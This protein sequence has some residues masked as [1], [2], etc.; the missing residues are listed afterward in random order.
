MPLPAGQFLLHEA[1]SIA[2]VGLAS[3]K[4]FARLGLVPV[5]AGGGVQGC[6]RRF[7]AVG[8]LVLCVVCEL[9]RRGLSRAAIGLAVAGLARLDVNSL[10]RALRDGR[11]FLVATDNSPPALIRASQL[12]ALLAKTQTAIV[13]NLSSLVSFDI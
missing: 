4:T 11:P 7:D 8:V 9:R 6:D 5:A 2:G 12:P 10:R 3:A 1:A 13:C